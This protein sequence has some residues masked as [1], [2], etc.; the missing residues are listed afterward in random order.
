MIPVKYLPLFCLLLFSHHLAGQA[1]QPDTL[2]KLKE[3][4]ITDRMARKISQ[5]FDTI[6][7]KTIEQMP[8]RDV[9]DFLRSQP[10][11]AG[12]RKGG[13]GID[14]V[15]RGF[16]YS[17]LNVQLNN[18][19]KIEGACPNRMDPPTSHVDIDD[20]R[21]IEIFRGPYALRFGPNFGGLIHMHTWPESQP[22]KFEVRINAVTGFESAWGGMK[23]NLSVKG[24]NK[25]FLLNLFGNYKK[26]GDYRDGNGNTVASSFERYNYGGI[27]S[28]TPSAKHA[29]TLFYEHAIGKNLDFPALAMD[30][31]LDK[32]SLYSADYE[33]RNPGEIFETL[34]FKIYQSDVR[35]E[36]DNK[37]R[38]ISDTTVAIAIIEALNTGYRAEAGINLAGGTLHA[39][40]DMEDIRKDGEREKYF[41]LQPTMPV[42]NEALW[43]NARTRN[44]GV[45]AEYSRLFSK[46]RG[47]AAFR[48]DFNQ[49]DSDPMTWENMQGQPVYNEENT[50]SS[51]TNFSFSLGTEWFLRKNLSLQLSAGRGVRSPDMTERFII[52][53]PIGYDNYDYLGNPSLLPEQ[54]YQADAALKYSH[55]AA[56]MV[57]FSIFYSHVRDY[58]TGTLLPESVVKPQTRGVYGVKQF[59]NIDYAWLTGF[60]VVYH[61]PVSHRWLLEMSAGY[62]YAVN[63]LATYHI[64]ENGQVTGKAEAKNDPL[65]E[66]PPLEGTLKFSWKF[67]NGKFIP[68]ADI[69]AVASQNRISK[70]Y[71]ERTSPGFILAGLSLFYQFNKVLE[72]SAGIDNIFNNAYY[73]HLNRNM[74]G[75]REDFYEPGR[76]VYINLRFRI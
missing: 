31:R 70:A 39:G 44:Y 37:Q 38:P 25:Y 66:I 40:T 5:P 18:G 71:D 19:Q 26:Y 20:I 12:I 45:F 56:G 69:R 57:T 61:T 23:Q 65:S 59:I 43:D 16:K 52:L 60:E 34:H 30:E 58:V 55:T 72:L 1:L 54:N 62:T 46:V 35:H 64:I 10:N 27:L 49:A 48:L 21:R 14:P 4:E 42:K 75:S 9:G 41:I 36:M 7:R 6:G 22:E 3:L 33:F 76:N 50:A 47:V 15:L 11:V 68:K 2:I 74:I 24:G 63:P 51:Y 53:L 8:V 73:E 67:F 29:V 17:Q 28:I 32:T 13:T